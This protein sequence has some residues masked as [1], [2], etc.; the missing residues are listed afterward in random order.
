MSLL[1]INRD[2]SPH[3]LHRFSWLCL[4]LLPTIAWLAGASF[5]LVI[6]LVGVGFALSFL[7]WSYPP[8]V[9]LVFVGTMLLTAPIGWMVSELTLMT[10]YLGVVLPI[11]IL[12][13]AMGRDALRIAPQ[14][15]ATTYWTAKRQPSSASSYFRRY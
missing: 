7:A 15:N 1:D 4:G 12:L 8:A 14:P 2:P 10:V 13:R 6:A 9:K 3:Q 5:A 11:G